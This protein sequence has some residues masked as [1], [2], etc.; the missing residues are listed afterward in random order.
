MEN[1]NK[2]LNRTTTQFLNDPTIPPDLKKKVRI[3]TERPGVY[4]QSSSEQNNIINFYL[5]K[6]DGNNPMQRAEVELNK[7]NKTMTLK[8]VFILT[9]TDYLGGGESRRILEVLDKELNIVTVRPAPYYNEKEMPKADTLTMS[10]LEYVRD[11]ED[12]NTFVTFSLA[13]RVANSK[14]DFNPLSHIPV[15]SYI[16]G[17]N[18]TQIRY[19]ESKVNSEDVVYHET[20]LARGGSKKK[21]KQIRK[22]QGIYQSGPK[23][24]KLKPGY[25]YSGKKT[26]TGLK[27]IVRK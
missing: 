9:D 2:I 15:P 18:K 19:Y 5:C 11:R 6:I 12:L 3:V 10:E 13:S 14:L 8:Q 20:K 1:L 21:S 16:E 24:G 26:K 27:V 4:V 25:R 23:K 17:N 22:H 7:R